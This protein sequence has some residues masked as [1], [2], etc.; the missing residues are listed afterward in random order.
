MFPRETSRV[1]SR[2]IK[3]TV[4]FYEAVRVCRPRRRRLFSDANR[5]LYFHPT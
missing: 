5:E 4:E 1:V 3:R 2:V